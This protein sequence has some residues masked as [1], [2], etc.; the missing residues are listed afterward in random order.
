MNILFTA[1][2][3]TQIETDISSRVQKTAPFNPEALPY[4]ACK[5]VVKAPTW[6]ARRNVL[7]NSPTDLDRARNKII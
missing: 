1:F 2:F 6:P 5:K 3:L 7:N 4:D